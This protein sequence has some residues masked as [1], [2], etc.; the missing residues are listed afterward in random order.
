M[1]ASLPWVSVDAIDLPCQGIGNRL[2]YPVARFIEGLAR[3]LHIRVKK[4]KDC[5]DKPRL[6]EMKGLDLELKAQDH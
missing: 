3:D 5:K 4:P 2:F 1:E 6:R